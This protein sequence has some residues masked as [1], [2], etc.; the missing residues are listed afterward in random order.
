[1]RRKRVIC[2]WFRRFRSGVTASV[3][4]RKRMVQSPVKWVMYSIGFAVSRRSKT[5]WT[6]YA[7]G[8][9]LKRNK[10]TLV[11]LLARTFGMLTTSIIPDQVHPRVHAGDLVPV[12]VEHQSLF[13]DALAEE[14]FAQPPLSRLGPARMVA[15]GIDVGI[16]AVFAGR[17]GGPIGRRLLFDEADLGNR[18]D[19]L[20]AVLPR[21]NQTQRRPVLIGQSFAVHSQA[22]Q[23]QRMHGFIQAET[24]LIGKGNSRFP[25]RD[26]VFRVVIGF[27]SHELG[28]AGRLDLFEQSAQRES[29]PRHDDRPCLDAAMAVDALFERREFR[30]GV[31][32][33][34][35][36]LHYLAADL[37]GPRRWD[38]P[39]RG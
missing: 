28:F 22:E 39:L 27:E 34:G 14:T 2:G 9:R 15:L 23:R 16:E 36:G 26:H 5:R 7:S 1:M 38:F 29:D 21:D 19:A 25:R 17:V 37:D 4:I 12:T 30:D 13:G 18:L 32:V 10:T 6:R 11:H 31:Q 24:F 20:E 33:D 35:F 3:I 8:T